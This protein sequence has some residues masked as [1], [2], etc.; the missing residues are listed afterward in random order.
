MQYNHAHEKNR[1]KARRAPLRRYRR[2]HLSARFAEESPFEKRLLTVL[3]DRGGR[4]PRGEDRQKRIHRVFRHKIRKAPQVFFLE[5]RSRAVQYRKGVFRVPLRSQTIESG[6]RIL[7]MRLRIPSGR[8]RREN[9]LNPGLSSR[10]RCH[11]RTFQP[12]G[13]EI[14]QN[15]IPR[16]RRSGQ[17]FSRQR[18]RRVMTIARPEH[19]MG[20][21]SRFEREEAQGAR[22]WRKPRFDPRV[23]S[24]FRSG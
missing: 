21:L 19:P 23:R 7:K 18:M 4:F 3:L 2:P 12:L 24:G 8:H 5:D 13:G 1:Q 22:H 15:R 11:P 9:P 17:I 10:V 20:R 14:L 6:I 16:F